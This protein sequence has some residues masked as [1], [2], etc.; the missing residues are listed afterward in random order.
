MIDLGPEFHRNARFLACLT[1]PRLD[2]EDR[3]RALL[4]EIT[5]EDWQQG[6]SA[7]G[8]WPDDCR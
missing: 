3:M 5:A 7:A 8:R 4:N 1:D 2:P 6:E